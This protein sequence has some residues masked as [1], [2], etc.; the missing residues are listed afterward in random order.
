MK[1]SGQ[2]AVPLANEGKGKF[3]L[4]EAGVIVQFH[5]GKSG[6]TL[7]YNGQDFEYSKDI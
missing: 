3:T 1:A 5:E 7:T 2:P 6:F 4:E